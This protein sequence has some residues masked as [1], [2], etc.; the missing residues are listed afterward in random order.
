MRE[1]GRTEPQ[2]L[3]F[4]YRRAIQRNPTAAESE[5][6]LKFY[7]RHLAEYQADSESAAALLN[8]GDGNRPPT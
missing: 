4:A 5:L 7:R 3:R 1:G 2:R 6:L 8:V